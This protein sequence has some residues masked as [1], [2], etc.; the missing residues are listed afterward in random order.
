MENSSHT[1]LGEG[2][3]KHTSPL[4]QLTHIRK[5]PAG[6]QGITGL[7]KNA[8]G[9]LVVYKISRYMNFLAEHEHYIMKGLNSLSDFC[10]H[11]CRVLDIKPIA[12][13][14][15]FKEKHANPFAKHAKPITINVLFMEYI[16]DSILLYDLIK[17]KSVP[18][19]V[20][21]AIMKQ[22]MIAIILAQREKKFVHYDLHSENI[23]IRK[24]DP[25]QVNLYKL[26][27]NNVV[28]VPTFGYIPV[29]ID[30]GFG[31]SDDNDGHPLSCSIAFTT[32]GYMSPAYDPF[33]DMK[34]F[35]TSLSRDLMYH[36]QCRETKLFRTMVKNIFLPLEIDWESGWDRKSG[37]DIVNQLYEYVEDENETS[38]VWDKYSHYC[39]DILQ[40]LVMLPMVR[41]D[42]VSLKELKKGFDWFMIEFRKIEIE[43]HNSYYALYVLHHLV[44]VAR[45]LRARYENEETRQE[46]IQIFSRSVFEIINPIAKFCQLK[47]INWDIL[48]CSLFV[49]QDQL[50]GHL[51]ILLNKIMKRKM[52]E[53]MQLD[54][55]G[56]DHIY[57]IFDLLFQTQFTG[58]TANEIVLFDFVNREKCEYD[59]DE[60]EWARVNDEHPAARGMAVWE[61]L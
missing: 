8:D 54:V 41:N 14:P 12:L 11:F 52:N 55:G 50:N 17:N 61:L 33:A 30:F 24:C 23:L 27:A 7:V 38:E 40:H 46:A 13:N 49:L 29:I 16:E 44:N 59:L 26:D 22:V 10:P 19:Y 9:Q 28:M 60:D 47:N 18:F 4:A 25:N 32:S 36:R 35:L 15:Y 51:Y 58:S 45:P 2:E 43:I 20:L 21:I 39:M 56:V 31:R 34:V 42:A 53:Y 57:A 6:K 37:L 48:L 5:F 3:D 1:D